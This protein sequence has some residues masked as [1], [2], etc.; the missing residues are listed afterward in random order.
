VTQ[1]EREDRKR[2]KSDHAAS[3]L[4]LCANGCEKA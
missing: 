2:R 1:P 3:T 4:R